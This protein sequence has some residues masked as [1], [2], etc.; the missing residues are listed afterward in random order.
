MARTLQSRKETVFGAEQ[1]FLCSGDACGASLRF[2]IYVALALRS[3]AALPSA[4]EILLDYK[5]LILLAY[6]LTNLAF[7][8]P[9]YL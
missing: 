1:P 5:A 6:R 4:I 3:L 8:I 7:I 9:L 2:R